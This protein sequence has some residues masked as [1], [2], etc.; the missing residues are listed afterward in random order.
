MFSLHSWAW[1]VLYISSVDEKHLPSPL[2]LLQIFLG[3]W[4]I[5]CVDINVKCCFCESI[6]YC[7]WGCILLESQTID[8]HYHSTVCFLDRWP[9]TKCK[10]TFTFEVSYALSHGSLG[11]AVHGSFFNHFLIGPNYSATNWDL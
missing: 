11:F 2:I 4:W 10:V 7:I 5:S 6:F 9:Q 8:L 1:R 3:L